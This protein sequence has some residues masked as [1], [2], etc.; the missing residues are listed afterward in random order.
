MIKFQTHTHTHTHIYIY[1]YIYKWIVINIRTIF[2]IMCVQKLNITKSL[3]TYSD[4]AIICFLIFK[5]WQIVYINTPMFSTK[6]V[7]R[8][9][10]YLPHSYWLDVVNMFPTGRQLRRCS[11]CAT[12]SINHVCWQGCFTEQGCATALSHLSGW[13]QVD[14]EYR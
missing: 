11:Q 3:F 9:L 14:V 12:V 2:K 8:L 1:I 6:R 7:F 4:I 13:W 5:L 10:L